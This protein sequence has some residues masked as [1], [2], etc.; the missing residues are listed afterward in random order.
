MSA[1]EKSV[2]V[3]GADGQLGSELCR[4]LGLRAR[5]FTRS[6]CDL[7]DRSQLQRL[8]E[9]YRPQIVINT[10]AYTAVDRAEVEATLCH[11]INADAVLTMAHS[12]RE[13]DATL[14]QISTDYVFGADQARNVPYVEEDE[15]SP[16]NSYARSKLVGEQ[17]AAEAGKYFVIRTGGLYGLR[18]KPTQNNFVD[19]MLRLSGERDVLRVVADQ[20]CTP[21]YTA[22]VAS[23]LL[24][25]MATNAYGLYHLVNAG[26]ATWYEFATEIFRIAGIEIQVEAIASSEY[27]TAAKRPNYSVLK[28]DKLNALGICLPTWNEALKEY[29]RSCGLN[30]S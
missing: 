29:L 14:V 18:A 27:K 25:L 3:T 10:A 19:T 15:P 2:I 21:S 6:E 9:E 13:I 23:A 7:S 11:E 30:R 17:Y 8:L 26:A 22:H 5:G 12:C 28:T 20:H 1:T 24:Q 16:L 4:Q